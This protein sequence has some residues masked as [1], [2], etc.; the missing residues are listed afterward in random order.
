MKPEVL[1]TLENMKARGYAVHT[2]DTAEQMRDFVIGA[3]PENESVGF[4][5]SVTV[6]RL[7]IAETLR[8]R[9]NAVYHHWALKDE[10]P[11][12]PEESREQQKFAH[13][14][15]NY[16][17]SAN[18]IAAN[19]KMLN[20][21]G[22]GNRVAALICGPKKVYILVGENKF[23]NSEDDAMMRCKTKAAPENA[24]RLK[25]KTPCAVTGVCADCQSPDSICKSVVW[26]LGVPNG[27]EYHICV[28]AEDL[29][30]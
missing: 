3:I 10:P 13:L 12:T 29:G 16:I 7:H 20:I 22:N 14:A 19:G 4:G 30:L 6:G 15:D 1:K 18:A 26:T 5:G 27:R 25:R 11:K 2:F 9:G 28:A 23:V 17:M 24:S 21:D 8:D